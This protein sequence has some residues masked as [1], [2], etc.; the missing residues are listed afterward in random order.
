[1]WRGGGKSSHYVMSRLWYGLIVCFFPRLFRCF[2]LH[3]HSFCSRASSHVRW[4]V[5]FF[6]G[7][8]SLNDCPTKS[9]MIKPYLQNDIILSTV[10]FWYQF[11]ERR[12]YYVSIKWGFS[13][14]LLLPR[15]CIV[16]KICTRNFHATAIS[17]CRMFARGIIAFFCIL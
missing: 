15:V 2:H 14:N 11:R 13:L 17:D 4:R 7:S 8:R 3:F 9:K 16:V 10:M 6:V 5:L 1:M 12:A